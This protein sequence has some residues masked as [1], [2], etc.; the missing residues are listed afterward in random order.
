MVFVDYLINLI[1]NPRHMGLSFEVVR[2]LAAC[3]DKYKGVIYNRKVVKESYFVAPRYKLATCTVHKSFSNM[4]TSILCYLKMEKVFLKRYN[5]LTDFSFQDRTCVTK[6]NNNLKS[7]G[8][9]IKI[10]SKGDEVNFLKTWKVI[11]VVR[12]PIERFIS[13]FVHLCYTH[14]VRHY[15]QFCLRC[16]KDF[17]CFVNKLQCDHSKNKNK[18]VVIKFDPKNLETFYK[19]LE[20]IFIQQNVPP[21][22]VEYIVKEIKTYRMGHSTTGK[23]KTI[24]FI[25]TFYKEK[26]VIEKLIEIYYSDFKE[27][28]FQIPN[29]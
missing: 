5:H 16:G 1:D 24:E 8:E 29:I 13:G 14:K 19:S 23:A 25:K 10:Y 17:K 4:I 7:F 11:M 15:K 6:K 9:L 21:E 28:D 22:K 12:N 18:F 20:K 2:S 26:D 3:N 27:F